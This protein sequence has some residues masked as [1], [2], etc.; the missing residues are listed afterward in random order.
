LLNHP[1]EVLSGSTILLGTQSSIDLK[2]EFV[3]TYRKGFRIVFLVG[4]GLS[5]LAVVFA[6]ALL[7][8]LELSQPDEAKLKDEG[9]R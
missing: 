3:D 7:P 6:F 9:K 4:A 2:D 1:S 5:A 8:Q